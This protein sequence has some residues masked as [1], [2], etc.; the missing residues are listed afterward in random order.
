MRIFTIVIIG[1]LNY[2]LFDLKH[3]RRNFSLR[4][5][6]T[7]S[8]ITYEDRKKKIKELQRKYKNRKFKKRKFYVRK[9]LKLKGSNPK[10]KRFTNQKA[11]RRMYRNS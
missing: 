4:S 11:L 8:S 5:S 1:A 7:T 9:D 6:S 2:V 3:S 10:A